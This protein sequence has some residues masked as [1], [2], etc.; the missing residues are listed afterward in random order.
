MRPMSVVVK[1]PV[2]SSH[3]PSERRDNRRVEVVKDDRCH[4]FQHHQRGFSEAW[5]WV[6]E[7]CST[8]RSVSAAC[9]QLSGGNRRS[10]RRLVCCH[11][12]IVVNAFLVHG[13]KAGF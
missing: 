3:A 2:S 11:R 10:Y 4:I 9:R 5:W 8:A 6:S 13:H 7:G 1:A 12:L